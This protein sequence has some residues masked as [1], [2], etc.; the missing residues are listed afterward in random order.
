MRKIILFALCLTSLLA[1]HGCGTE[2][3]SSSTG[4]T[5]TPPTGINVGPPASVV[6]A[7][8]LAQ[9]ALLSQGGQTT[10]TATVT[11]SNGYAVADGTA[12]S[13]FATS[14]SVT[15]A[16]ATAN[17]KATATFHA[18]NT[19]GLVTLTATA[20]GITSN[21]VS[22]Q[23]AAGSA[24]TITFVSADPT[25]IGVK[26]SGQP[27]SATLTFQVLDSG[28]NPVDDGTLVNF[29]IATPLGGGETIAPSQSSTTSGLVTTN[30]QSGSV[31][32]AVS[33]SATVMDSGGTT[34][35]TIAQVIIAAGLP[36]SKHFSLATTKLN[37][38]GYTYFGE[39]SKITA[40]VADR[41]SN[42]VPAN[43]PV[44]FESEAGAMALT[45]AFTNDLGQASA[46]HITQLPYPDTILSMTNL[47]GVSTILAW[48]PGQEAFSDNNGNGRYDTG[49]SFDDIGEPFI[50]ANDNGQ[51]D[52]TGDVATDER[53]VDLNN[54]GQY[55]GP[56]GKWDGS[57]FVWDTINI[58]WSFANPSDIFLDVTP[59]ANCPGFVIPNGEGCECTIEVV[60]SNGSPIYGGSGLSVH[61]SI[62]SGAFTTSPST[63]TIPDASRP[64][65]DTT[66][67]NFNVT[68]SSIANT[69]FAFPLTVTLD[70]PAIAGSSAFSK[71]KTVT[72]T[73]SPP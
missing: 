63:F 11:D 31:P 23:V 72:I 43:T 12:V 45:Q 60:D 2:S 44:Y 47:P 27:E 66:L 36:D 21:A 56:N 16:S 29:A 51:F 55:D 35:S 8:N 65:L 70:V 59:A 39:T 20:S 50:D 17:G 4:G 25:S 48:T 15:S 46:D 53:Y 6:L 18:G 5:V 19:G 34:I 42:P 26:S 54:N 33:V 61:T 37:L 1:L 69:P 24:A 38:P 57:T 52:A 73:L 64:G 67:F 10:L 30:L 41:F 9:G 49:E 68:N 7:S 71:T 32:G 14:G 13:F 40:F 62:S 22:I 3:T 58:L 28:G